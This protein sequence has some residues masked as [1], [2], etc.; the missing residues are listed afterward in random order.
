[1]DITQSKNKSD[2]ESDDYMSPMKYVKIPKSFENIQRVKSINLKNFY[3]KSTNNISVPNTSIT[4]FQKIINSNNNSK[5]FYKLKYKNNN[6]TNSIKQIKNEYKLRYMSALKSKKIIKNNIL[7]VNSALNNNSTST[8]CTKYTNSF[9][10]KKEKKIIKRNSCQNISQTTKITS[11]IQGKENSY[12]YLIKKLKPAKIDYNLE[13]QK[14]IVNIIL[15]NKVKYPLKLR[16][17]SD[18]HQNSDHID[19]YVKQ[20]NRKVLKLLKN[21]NYSLFYSTFN[22]VS[23]GKFSKEFENPVYSSQRRNKNKNLVDENILCGRKMLKEMN[24]NLALIKNKKNDKHKLYEKFKNKMKEILLIFYDMKATLSDIIK[25]YHLKKSMY[26]FSNIQD[27]FFYLKVKDFELSNLLLSNN[28]CLALDND[29]FHRTPLHFAVKNNFFQIIPKLIEF[30]AYVDSKNF[31]G[32][33]PLVLSAKKNFIESIVLL[34]FYLA[35]PYECDKDGKTI[36]NCMTDSNSRIAF[37]K[38]LEIYDKYKNL[39][40]RKKFETIQRKFSEFISIEF[41]N[42]INNECYSF[43]RAKHNYFQFYTSDDN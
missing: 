34:L 37:S 17:N 11:E 9:F 1:M 35:S 15:R 27:L 38:I 39:K 36:K 10:P 26:N 4:L 30:G 20:Y 5:H 40:G 29:Q 19:E 18:L 12:H 28:N 14:K 8:L 2:M 32:E 31:L 33:T 6:S 43:I 7:R 41:K 42:Y 21:Q 24:N 13:K 22:L 16:N 25:Y 23:K 3:N